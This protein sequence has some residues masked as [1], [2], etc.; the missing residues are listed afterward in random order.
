VPLLLAVNPVGVRTGCGCGPASTKEPPLA[1]TFVARRRHP[2]PQV[3]R[4][5]GPARGPSVVDKG[6]AGKAT[7]ARWWQTDG[8][9][10]SCPPK[11]QSQTP[12]PQALRRW[13]AGGRQIVETVYDKLVQPFRLDRERP[14]DLSGLWA[15]VAAKIALHNFCIWL[16]EQLGRPRLAFTDIVDW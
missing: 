1:D 12:W 6:F 11:R 10:V 9:E 4:V 8:A 3:P 16:K 7:Q 13:L 5:G 15:R 2:H 14:H